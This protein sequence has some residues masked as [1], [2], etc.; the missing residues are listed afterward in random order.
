MLFIDNQNITDPRINLAIE[1]YCLKHLDPEETYL[2]FYINQPSIIIG[3]NQN[4]IEEINTKYVDENGIIVVRRLSGG[5]AV[6]HDLGNLNFSFI[7]KDDGNSF[8]NFKKFTEPVVAALKKL[9]V[10]AELSGRNDLMANGRKISGNAQFSTKGRMF[11]HGTLLF[12]SEIEHVVSALKVKKDKIESKGIKSIRSRV[13]N[14]SEFLDQKMTTVEFRSMLLR[15]IFDTEGEI[16]EYK[17]TEK[18]WEIINQISKER[19]QN[20]DWNYGKSPKFNLQHSKR[21]QAG[22]VDIRLEVQKGVIRE[23]KIFGDFFGV[24]DVSDIEEKLKGVQYERK[25][26]EE[27]L[28]GVDIKHYFGNIQKE[29]FLE[30]VY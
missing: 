30:L 24:G 8:H 29:E 21:F 4:T 1:E 16:P 23:C 26:I 17:L 20:W 15:Y 27:A 11:S 10:D 13:A 22:S 3:K 12:D 6:Y 2:L 25:A 5:G 28:Q 9:G 18:D 7:T 14:I 19:Y